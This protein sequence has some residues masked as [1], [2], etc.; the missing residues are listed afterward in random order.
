MSAAPVVKLSVE[1]YLAA[2][3]VA[4]RQSEYHDGE[5]FPIA[6]VTWEHGLIVGNT[7][8]ALVQRLEKT[9]CRLAV[10]PVR[11]RA[12][13]TKFLF[14]DI[15]IVCGKPAF[16]DEAADTITNPKLIVEVL[17]P[18][19]ADFDYGGKFA[20]YRRLAT[21]DEYVLIAQDKPNVDVFF[22]SPDGRWILSSTES[23][24]ASV[25]LDSL[26]IALPMAELYSGVEFKP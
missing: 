20:L 26:G 8:H 12:T 6:D 7:A 21:L 18:S 15:M 11:V 10:S 23:L 24:E 5:M 14:P 1:E 3:R 19:T 17:S 16:T 25:K 9:P 13:S 22:R 4:E 2:D